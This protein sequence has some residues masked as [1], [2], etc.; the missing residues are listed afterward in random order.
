MHNPSSPECQRLLNSLSEFIDNELPFEGQQRL[1]A[2]LA[3]CQDCRVLVQT[4]EKTLQLYQRLEQPILPPEAV[5]RLWQTL[6]SEGCL[7]PD[8]PETPNSM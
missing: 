2:H 6:K 3:G 1:K 5:D 4:M 8:Q 7:D